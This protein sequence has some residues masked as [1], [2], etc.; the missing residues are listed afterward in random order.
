[1]WRAEIA[2]VAIYTVCV[3]SSAHAQIVTAL[4]V[5]KAMLDQHLIDKS[6]SSFV[7]DTMRAE[8]SHF[9]FYRN[10]RGS[11]SASG[12]LGFAIFNFLAGQANTSNFSNRQKT[13]WLCGEGKKKFETYIAANIDVQT[14]QYVLDAVNDC[15]KTATNAGVPVIT[16]TTSNDYQADDRFTVNIRY[17]PQVLNLKYFFSNVEG[18]PYV[19]CSVDGHDAKG[20][21]IQ[22]ESLTMTCTKRPRIL[23]QGTLVFRSEHPND[24]KPLSFQV[25]SPVFEEEYRRSI[26]KEIDAKIEQLVGELRQKIDKNSQQL[27]TEFNNVKYIIWPSQQNCPPG[28]TNLGLVGVIMPKVT[29]EHN[30]LGEGEDYNKGWKWTHPF[31]CRRN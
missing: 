20:T 7:S 3:T 5:C 11:H 15:I 17:T 22:G 9:C 21:E 8:F 12:G 4:D 14:G 24:A 13:D 16:G 19:S 6:S 26:K 1:M 25:G 18:N 2:A 28:W 10:E 29:Y 27:E 31:L 23:A 30:H